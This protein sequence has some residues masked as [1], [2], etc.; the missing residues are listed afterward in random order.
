MSQITYSD[1]TIPRKVHKGVVNGLGEMKAPHAAP[2]HASGL[3]FTDDW[4]KVTCNICNQI[5]RAKIT[6]AGLVS[7]RLIGRIK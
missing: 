1:K 4:S 2:G 6:K 7:R 3:V 5:R